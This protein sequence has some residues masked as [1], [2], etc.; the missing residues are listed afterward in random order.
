MVHVQENNTLFSILKASDRFSNE[1]DE[2]LRILTLSI[3]VSCNAVLYDFF[4]L[5]FL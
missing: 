4:V 5:G 3:S 2:Q 1:T